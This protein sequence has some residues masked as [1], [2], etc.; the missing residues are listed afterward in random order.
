MLP[1]DDGIEGIPTSEASDYPGPEGVAARHHP[2]LE[3][4][5]RG[6]FPHPNLGEDRIEQ[7]GRT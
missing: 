3:P 6:S 1:T 2:G 7:W 5:P 4:N